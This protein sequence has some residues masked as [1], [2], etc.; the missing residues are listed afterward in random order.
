MDNVKPLP[1]QYKK[2]SIK[3]ENI[4]IKDFLGLDSWDQEGL[5]NDLIVDGI[6]PIWIR[7]LSTEAQAVVLLELKYFQ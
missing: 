2:G 7:L 5:I 4:T 3:L 1:P 6:L